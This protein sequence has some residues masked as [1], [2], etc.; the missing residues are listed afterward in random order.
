MAAF[1]LI[2]CIIA[3]VVLFFIPQPF[4]SQGFHTARADRV[5]CAGVAIAVF[6]DVTLDPEL[7]HGAVHRAAA[8]FGS[9]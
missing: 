4:H 8:V 5:G 6:P 9:A 7:F 1:E 2:V 3:A